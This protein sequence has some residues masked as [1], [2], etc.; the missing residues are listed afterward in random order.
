MKALYTIV[1]A[2]IIYAG[3]ASSIVLLIHTWNKHEA[4]SAPVKRKAV[5]V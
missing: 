4:C 2:A 1:M 3:S 5:Q